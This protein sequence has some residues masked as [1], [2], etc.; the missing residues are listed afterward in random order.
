MDKKEKKIKYNKACE[1]ISRSSGK[2]KQLVEILLDLKHLM[3]MRSKA[4]L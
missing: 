3:L 2:G 1:Y 4:C